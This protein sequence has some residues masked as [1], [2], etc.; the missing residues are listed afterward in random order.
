MSPEK[1]GKMNQRLGEDAG[2]ISVY[3]NSEKEMMNNSGEKWMIEAE[4][5]T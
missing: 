5:E 1:H 2:N 4:G 3:P